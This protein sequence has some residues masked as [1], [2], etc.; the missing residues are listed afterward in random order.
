[1]LQVIWFFIFSS[2]FFFSKRRHTLPKEDSHSAQTIGIILMCYCSECHTCLLLL[3]R[4][5]QLY[6]QSVLLETGRDGG[7]PECAS[8][9]VALRSASIFWF[10][11][12]G[13][14]CPTAVLQSSLEILSPTPYPKLVN[15]NQKNRVECAGKYTLCSIV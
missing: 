11:F 12:L 2:F 7:N 6:T 13:R 9:G 5:I 10:T 14:I 4:R 3:I 8:S 1:M 15:C